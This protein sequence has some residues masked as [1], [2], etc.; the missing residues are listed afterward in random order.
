MTGY[1]N[2]KRYIRNATFIQYIDGSVFLSYDAYQL[3]SRN[4][5]QNV[6]M[7]FAHIGYI[8]FPTDHDL[9]F[10]RE[11]RTFKDIAISNKC[12]ISTF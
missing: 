3:Y 6:A 5:L 9:Y 10:R 8:Y 1:M 7:L 12:F 11:I 4:Y 2:Y